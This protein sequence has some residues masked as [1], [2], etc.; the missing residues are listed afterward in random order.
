MP[1]GGSLESRGMKMP[2]PRSTGD[3][4]GR[5]AGR[6]GDPACGIKISE[7]FPT[8]PYAER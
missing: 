5:S 1:P 8:K 3:R 2:A 7:D 6:G 4:I